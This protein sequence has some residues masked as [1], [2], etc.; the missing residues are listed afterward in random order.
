MVTAQYGLPKPWHLVGTDQYNLPRPW[1][2]DPIQ[3]LSSAPAP[4][5]DM[6]SPLVLA[7]QPKVHAAPEVLAKVEPAARAARA[8]APPKKKR[9]IRKQPPDDYRRETEIMLRSA[10]TDSSSAASERA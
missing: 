3:I 10:V 2:P 9:V 8:E 1:R 6:T 7:A 5:P 4:A